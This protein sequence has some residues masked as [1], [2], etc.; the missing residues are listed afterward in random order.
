MY[1]LMKKGTE[2]EVRHFKAGTKGVEEMAKEA[3]SA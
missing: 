2:Y 3:I 1:T